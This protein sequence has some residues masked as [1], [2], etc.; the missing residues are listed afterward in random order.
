MPVPG[1][2]EQIDYRSQQPGGPFGRPLL[3]L[4]SG[5]YPVAG[6]EA[7]VTDGVATT[8]GVTMGATIDLDGVRREV[9][10]VVQNPS[11]FDDEFVL[12][13][14]SELASADSV[15]MLVNASS[16]RVESFRPPGYTHRIVGSRG[17]VPED[18]AAAVITLVVSTL[19][20]FLVAL[21]G[22]ASFMVIAQRRLPQL[23]MMAAVGASE[24]APSADDGR[25]GAR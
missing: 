14:A 20:L 5:R 24:E 23:G 10:G 12:L 11:D 21:I 2:A 25:G 1:Q 6:G 4:E 17:D 7:A 16:D 8:L 19:V 3:E 22:A 13:P 15:T 9:V 18:V